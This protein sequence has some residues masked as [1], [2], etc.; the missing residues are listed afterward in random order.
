M[1][2]GKVLTWIMILIL[3]ICFWGVDSASYRSRRTYSS[4]PGMEPWMIAI[5]VISCISIIA[6]PVILM[7]CIKCGC[8]KVKQRNDLNQPQVMV[9]APGQQYNAP[10]GY[11]T[12]ASHT[13]ANGN[14]FGYMGTQPVP[15]PSQ[16]NYPPS[17]GEKY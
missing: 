8:C 14:Q 11:N 3:M 15:S 12:T 6:V 10:Y 5:I 16:Y 13:M 17:T 7:I 1:A 4:S 9:T 2:V